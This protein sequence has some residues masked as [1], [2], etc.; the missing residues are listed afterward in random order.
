MKYLI[1]RGVFT[2]S[3]SPVHSAAIEMSLY[4]F[5]KPVTVKK[6]PDPNGELSATVSPPAIRAANKEVMDM[7]ITEHGKRKP[8]KKINDSLRAKIAQYAIQNGN[9]A[10]VRKFSKEFDTPLNE[11]TVR[12]LKKSY[13]TAQE[14]RKRKTGEVDIVLESLP[15]KK[16]GRPLLLSDNLDTQVQAYVKVSRG[17]GCIINTSLVIAGAMGIIKKTNPALLENNPELLS[18][19]WAKS[20]LIRMGYVKRRGTTTAK[21]NPDNFENLRETFLEQIRSTVLF[22]DI[23]LDLIFNW[24]Q[25]GLNYVP[26]SNWTMEKE[27]AK[28]V[29]IKG[30]D[31]KRQITAV[32][33]GTLTGEFLPMQ[34][35]YQGRTTQCH[36]NSKFPDDWHITHSDNHWSNETTMINYIAKIIIP[37][38][39]KKRR[40]LKKT[41]DQVALAIFD[42]FKGQVT[43]ACCEMLWENNILF[44]RV[45]A[46]C[47]DRLQPLD[48]SLNK[49][50]KDFLRRQFQE[51]YSNQILKQLNDGVEVK[52]LVPVDL[53]LSTIK[54]IGAEW[55]KSMFYYFSNKPEIIRNGFKHVGIT[56]VLN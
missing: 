30:L 20:V 22:E 44:I 5:F 53:R 47:T 51:W 11:S 40:E 24:D 39:R 28:R 1:E 55:I 16:R 6:L 43:Q 37:F 19:S 38:V 18:K 9:A 2:F 27:G 49:A 54:P 25:T 52:D 35:V 12:S 14:A 42:E 48:V 50:A 3:C 10:A 26:V 21:I 56:G 31:D 23:P 17:Q 36:P 15:P 4:R 13:V 41:E 29:E 8:Y 46:N 7:E 45:P 33:G 34:L 32:F